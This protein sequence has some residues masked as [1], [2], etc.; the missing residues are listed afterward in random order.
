MGAFNENFY[1][2]YP[3]NNIIILIKILSFRLPL[4]IKKKCARKVVFANFLF[5]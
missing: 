4:F 1:F 2:N 3:Q 5:W